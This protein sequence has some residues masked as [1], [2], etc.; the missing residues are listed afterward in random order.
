MTV[1]YLSEKNGPNVGRRIHLSSAV[2]TL[3]RRE[4]DVLIDDQYVSWLH[5]QITFDGDAYY[6]TDLDSR[7]KT[8]LNGRELPPSSRSGY[9]TET[10][11]PSPEFAIS[12]FIAAK[13]VLLGLL[14]NGR[15]T[16]RDP[17]PIPRSIPSW[18][19]TPVRPRR[20]RR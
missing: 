6:V 10:G 2:L 17:I 1:A 12:S 19:R 11:S 5:A 3:G 8:V 4:G 9:T 16:K 14:S 20:Q 18:R 7:N 13:A 15:T